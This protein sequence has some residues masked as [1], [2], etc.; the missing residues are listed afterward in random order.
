MMQPT[1]WQMEK[2]LYRNSLNAMLSQQKLEVTEAMMREK[3]LGQKAVMGPEWEPAGIVSRRMAELIGNS[4]KAPLPVPQARKSH[5][6]S[7]G[8]YVMA[9]PPQYQGEYAEEERQQY[10]AEASRPSPTMMQRNQ[11][12]QID[13]QGMAFSPHRVPAAAMPAPL[14]RDTPHISKAANAMGGSRAASTTALPGDV[15]QRYA[16]GPCGSQLAREL[17]GGRELPQGHEKEIHADALPR[18]MALGTS[19]SPTLAWYPGLN[20]NG[21]LGRM[22]PNA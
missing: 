12:H 11:D 20:M 16:A 10:R 21:R 18:R 4:G 13:W 2:S 22:G 14:P 8:E 1:R 19:S 9:M 5:L 3:T 17:R 15:S 6:A 7:A